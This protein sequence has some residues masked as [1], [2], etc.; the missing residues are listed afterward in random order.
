MNPHST[1][2]KMTSPTPT[3]GQ[4]SN[5]TKPKDEARATDALIACPIVL[6]GDGKSTTQP[7]VASRDKVL[8]ILQTRLTIHR[9]KVMHPITFNVVE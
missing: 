8:D 9:P 1:V 2:K 5:K 7:V 3:N 6:V 4:L